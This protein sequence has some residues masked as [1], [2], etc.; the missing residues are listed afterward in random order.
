MATADYN[1]LGGGDGGTATNFI[2]SIQC[3][4]SIVMPFREFLIS[5]E[6]L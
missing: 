2:I 4:S 5:L 6:N 3:Y 1:D